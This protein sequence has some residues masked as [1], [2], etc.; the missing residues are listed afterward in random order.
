[1][2]FINFRADRAREISQ[3][4]IQS[5]FDGFERR[6]PK[7]SSFVCM[8]RYLDSLPAEIAFPPNR[9]MVCSVKLSQTRVFRQL[10]IAETE[11]YAHVTFFFNGGEEKSFPVNSVTGAFTRCSHL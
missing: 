2:I 8:T 3:A 1:M 5:E 10:R 6:Q 7:L 11:K 4:F 9:S